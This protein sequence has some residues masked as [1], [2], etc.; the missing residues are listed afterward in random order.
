MK[1][2]S[3][4]DGVVI[5]RKDDGTFV[6]TDDEGFVVFNMPDEHRNSVKTTEWRDWKIMN[7]AL[8]SGS[9][10]VRELA[11]QLILEGVPKR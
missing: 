11:M 6:Y 5:L 1:V 10:I 8:T 4:R 7:N 3:E 2:I 9:P